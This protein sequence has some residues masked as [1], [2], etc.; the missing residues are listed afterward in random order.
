MTYLFS[1]SAVESVFS[2]MGSNEKSSVNKIISEIPSSMILSQ[3]SSDFDYSS[4]ITSLTSID[5]GRKLIS[6]S[7]IPSSNI[8]QFEK[9]AAASGN[10]SRSLTGDLS[11]GKIISS[12]FVFKNSGL[13]EDAVNSGKNKFLSSISGIKS[14]NF[15]SAETSMLESKQKNSS[16]VIAIHNSSSI[17]VNLRWICNEFDKLYNRRKYVHWYIGEGMEESEFSE[18]REKL[19]LLVSKYENCD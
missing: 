19:E 12:H 16:A 10:D 18:V 8:K 9:F 2:K 3:D 6:S 13:N 11:K 7:Y 14:S 17:S 1:N 5:E 4:F 15:K